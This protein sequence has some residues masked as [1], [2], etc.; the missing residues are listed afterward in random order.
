MFPRI[1]LFGF[2]FILLP[3]QGLPVGLAAYDDAVLK[4]IKSTR[5][6]AA[7]I[8]IEANAPARF[9]RLRDSWETIENFYVHDQGFGSRLRL[10]SAEFIEIYQREN[11]N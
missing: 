11:T 6:A 8:Q 1:I 2:V 9:N 7:I 4:M 5:E 3:F 10:D